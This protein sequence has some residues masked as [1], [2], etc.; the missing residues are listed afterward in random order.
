MSLRSDILRI[1]D[2]DENM[3]QHGRRQYWTDQ[4]ILMV[5]RDERERARALVES[6][7]FD[8]FTLGRATGRAEE[9]DRIRQAV[10]ALESEDDCETCSVM[11][12][13]VLAAID[14]PPDD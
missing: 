12:A 7:D 8:G 11:Q 6:E 13:Q 9:R 10:E 14:G 4:I 2:R 3:S 5:Q 1:L